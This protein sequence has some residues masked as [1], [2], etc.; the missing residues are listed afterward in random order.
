M[1]IT[2]RHGSSLDDIICQGIMDLALDDPAITDLETWL[3]KEHQNRFRLPK[4]GGRRLIASIDRKD[5]AFADYLISKQHIK[6][7]FVHP[8]YQRNGIGAN[9]LNLVQEQIKDT[10]SVNVLSINKNAVLWY[11]GRGFKVSN[12]WSERFNGKKTGWLKL[13]RADV[14]L[15]S[16]NPSKKLK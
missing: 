12:C 14:T 1:K 15:Q 9:L 5:V 10:I 13:T 7:L 4:L 3:S 2:L 6:Y 8:S 11:L 16:Q